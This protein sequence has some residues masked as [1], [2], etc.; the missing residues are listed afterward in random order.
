MLAVPYVFTTTTT[1][2]TTRRVF[3]FFLILK[4]EIGRAGWCVVY[5]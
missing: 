1:T 5:F 3:F 4:C 2:T